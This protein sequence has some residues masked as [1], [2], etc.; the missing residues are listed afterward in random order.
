MPTDP[1]KWSHHH[2]ELRLHT[3]LTSHVLSY[4]DPIMVWIDFL[5]AHGGY[6]TLMGIPALIAAV[7]FIGR[8][9]WLK[10]NR[11][12]HP[13]GRTNL[14]YWPTQICIAIACSI[15]LSFVAS[16]TRTSSPGDGLL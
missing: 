9:R 1:S 14:I 8:M 10:Q 13:Y 6:L 12:P 4:N 15:L 2:P 3:G 7:S 16:L 11:V 5:M